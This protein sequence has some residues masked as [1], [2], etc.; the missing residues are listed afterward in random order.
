M[1]AL[2]GARRHSDYLIERARTLFP[3]RTPESK[4]KAMNFLLPHMR[5]MPDA[6]HRDEFAA[7]AAQKLAIDSALLRNELRQAAARRVESLP[8]ARTASATQIDIVL[9]QA[10]LLPAADAT[11]AEVANRLCDSPDLYADLASAGLLECL[12]NSTLYDDVLA[13]A[14]DE[15]GRRLLAEILAHPI[16]PLALREQ[17]LGVLYT[18]EGRRLERRMRELKTTTAE[19]LR[20]NDP[21]ALRQLDL[22]R[23]ALQQ[24]LRSRKLSEAPGPEL[25][26]R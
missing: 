24:Q 5:R 2:R 17:A 3:A 12:L 20:K 21:A 23:H 13:N 1:T 10:L 7:D 26:S 22:Q 18:L 6:L 19:A 16:E 8:T 15:P 11:R 25:L 4:L 14:P 9:V